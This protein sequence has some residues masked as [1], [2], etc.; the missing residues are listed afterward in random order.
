MKAFRTYLRES[1]DAVYYHGTAAEN[2]DSILANGLIP[3]AVASKNDEL[4]QSTGER[5]NCVYLTRD[6]ATA[7][8][9]GDGAVVTV[10][11]PPDFDS[12]ITQDEE[13]K[14]GVRFRGHIPAD[15][16]SR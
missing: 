5:T 3:H 7:E 4:T 14:Q 6:Y 9:Y 1:T 13:D 12:N 15:W 10:S 8:K 11:V 16:I 2:V